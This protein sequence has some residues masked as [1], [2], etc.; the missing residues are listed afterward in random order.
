MKQTDWKIVY[1]SYEAEEKRAI[2]LLSKELS[3][4]LIRE[5]GEYRLHVLPCEKDGCEMPVN[6]IVVGT[7]EESNVVKKFVLADEIPQNGFLV[8]VI[9]NPDN[10][11][12]RIVILTAHTK[13]ELFYAAVSFLD[14]Y[15]PEYAPRFAVNPMPDWIFNEPLPECSYTETTDNKTRSIFTWG[16]STNDYRSYIDNMARLKFNE[17]VLWNDYIPL[18]IDEIIDY[19]HSYGIK[20]IL[21]YSW[22]WREIGNR[23]GS[24]SSEDIEKVKEI[25]IREYKE[26]YSIHNC[27]GIYF[28][29]FTERKEESV[30]GGVIAQLV[31]DMVNDVAGKLWEITPDLRII[32]GLHATSVRNRLDIIENV[33]PRMEILWEDCGGFP[34]NYKTDIDSAEE[35][36]KDKEFTKKLLQ[37]RGGKGVGLVFKGVMMLNWD[38]FIYQAG[39]YVMGENSPEV[40]DHDRAVRTKAWKIYSAEWLKNGKYASEM[41]RYIKENK[42]DEVNMCAAGTFDGGIYFPLAMYAQ[43]FRDCGE[44]H[45]EIV[46]KVV[47]RECVDV[48]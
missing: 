1:S 22:G 2:N 12:G 26:N 28:Q 44:E 9:K 30:E 31:T 23:T 36:E 6:A 11:N 47:R 39:P 21:G 35:F 15:I 45:D 25:A 4:N 19:A 32:F 27:D 42:M 40:A 24:I 13:Q 17:I 5:K 3:R 14:D 46:K 16:H 20:I 29:A 48:E 10:E 37:L 8:R 7:Y 41:I 43:L 38:N 34:Y 18:N 33:D